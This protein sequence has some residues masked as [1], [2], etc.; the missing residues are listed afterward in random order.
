MSL[1]KLAK[2][3]IVILAVGIVLAVIPFKEE[4]I[5]T[6]YKAQISDW[7]VT[8]YYLLVE[9]TSEGFTENYL[10]NSALFL[11]NATFP[12]I[13]WYNWGGETVFGGFGGQMGFIARAEL[14]MPVDGFV[15][16]E[17]I[18]SDGAR[19]YI[20][21]EIVVDAWETRWGQT[22][23]SGWA[24]PE[25]EAGKHILELHVYMWGWAVTGFETDRTI[26]AR[27]RKSELLIGLA[28]ACVG[29]ALMALSKLKA[30]QS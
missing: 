23:G 13:F 25:I 21:G 1:S 28:V 29:V 6:E 7:N 20:D 24:T 14:E 30:K 4:V 15:K 8:W 18:S 17:A 5:Q 3:G 27:V 12:A 9:P 19:L 22:V 11:G 10:M 16:F 26:M 2:I